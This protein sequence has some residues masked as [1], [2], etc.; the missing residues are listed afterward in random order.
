MPM[1]R[2]SGRVIERVTTTVQATATARAPSQSTPSTVRPVTAWASMFAF[3]T[4]AIF[5]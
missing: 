4:A 2:C 1:A 5:L 3:S